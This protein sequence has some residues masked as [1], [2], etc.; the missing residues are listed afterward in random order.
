MANIM[1]T[2]CIFTLLLK[3]HLPQPHLAHVSLAFLLPW[4]VLLV[5]AP[6]A[7]KTLGELGFPLPVINGVGKN[8][9]C[10]W[11]FRQ[12]QTQNTRCK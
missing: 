5:P 12:T 4:L 3:V 2:Y 8:P 9:A 6:V 11:W 7:M 10:W 1:P